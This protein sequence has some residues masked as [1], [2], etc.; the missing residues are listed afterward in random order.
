MTTARAPITSEAMAQISRAFAAVSLC[1]GMGMI[2]GCG[3]LMHRLHLDE[4]VLHSDPAE[5]VVLSNRPVQGKGTTY[6][7]IVAF[8]D[9]TGRPVTFQDPMA[10]GRPSFSEGQK[11]KVFYDRL[12]PESAM[13]DRGIK[14]YVIPLICL[15]FAG[16]CILGGLQRIAIGR[17]R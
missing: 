12:R 1:I 5:G 6:A 7:A 9:S 15:T 3:F 14:N 4:F 13:V 2:V 16:F 11:V 17:P 8:T 10:F